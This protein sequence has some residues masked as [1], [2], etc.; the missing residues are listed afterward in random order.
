[1]LQVGSCFPSRGAITPFT[2]IPC[3]HPTQIS[4][5]PGKL[6]AGFR[7]FVLRGV[8][9]GLSGR[10]MPLD[11]A[12]L[13]LLSFSPEASD[14]CIYSVFGVNLRGLLFLGSCALWS[15]C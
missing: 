13:S 10:F 5:P 6:R 14:G 3:L 8:G 2:I 11:S 1:M 15:V 12:M 9:V 7:T 4:F